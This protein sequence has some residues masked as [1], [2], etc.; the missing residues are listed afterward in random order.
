[1][2]VLMTPP[3]QYGTR[4]RGYNS[5]IRPMPSPAAIIA[6][7]VSGQKY[8]FTMVFACSWKR[9]SNAATMAKRAV[10][11]TADTPKNNA[12]GN[13]MNPAHIAISLYGIGVN[14]VRTIINLSLIHISEPTRR[15]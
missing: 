10:R 9:H 8:F 2:A 11:N 12:A 4:A 14:A 13:P 5:I 6:N 7:M 1:M 3:P 15:P